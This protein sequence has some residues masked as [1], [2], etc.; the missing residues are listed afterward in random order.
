MVLGHSALQEETPTPRSTPLQHRLKSSLEERSRRHSRS[1]SNTLLNIYNFLKYRN[2]TNP[3]QQPGRGAALMATKMISGWSP[4]KPCRVWSHETLPKPPP[5]SK[6]CCL[7]FLYFL[8]EAVSGLY[9]RHVKMMFGPVFQIS[10]DY[11]RQSFWIIY[12]VSHGWWSS[13]VKETVIVRWES[14]QRRKHKHK[15]GEKW[16][17][18]D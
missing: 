8:L 1:F 17:Q 18:N 16:R 3:G 10:T 5:P 11:V 13:S 12:C 6:R 7:V 15:P 4:I 2:E 14:K 9:V